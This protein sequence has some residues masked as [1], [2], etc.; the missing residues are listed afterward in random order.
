MIFFFLVAALA[1]L[2]TFA[3]SLFP[4]PTFLALPTAV[5]DS[6]YTVAAYANW[7]LNL[8]GP[9]V[10]SAFLVVIGL[11]LGIGVTIF[12]WNVVRKFHFPIIEKFLHN[13]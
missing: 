8:F 12:L 9:T 6:L 11:T 2:T 10:R 3:F 7:F 13:E 5:Y 1:A 4:G